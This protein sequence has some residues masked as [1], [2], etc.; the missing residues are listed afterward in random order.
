[1]A[2]WYNMTVANSTISLVFV[3]SWPPVCPHLPGLGGT[4]VVPTIYTV[5]ATKILLTVLS[6]ILSKATVGPAP[7]R[8]GRTMIA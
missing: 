7:R 2:G 4:S 8:S 6:G 5:L 1:M 3:M